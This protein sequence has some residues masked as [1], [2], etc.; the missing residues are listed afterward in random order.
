MESLV[1]VMTMQ[2]LEKYGI[3]PLEALKRYG[4]WLENEIPNDGSY[5]YYMTDLK[6]C[7]YTRFIVYKYDV[8]TWYTGIEKYDEEFIKKY[9]KSFSLVSHREWERYSQWDLDHEM[10]GKKEPTMLKA[11]LDPSITKRLYELYIDSEI[12]ACK[13]RNENYDLEQITNRA[14]H[15]GW[16]IELAHQ[17]ILDLMIYERKSKDSAKANES[18]INVKEQEEQLSNKELLDNLKATPID[19]IDSTLLP[20]VNLVAREKEVLELVKAEIR[21]S[22]SLDYKSEIEIYNQEVAKDKKLIMV[23]GIPGAGKS[24]IAPKYSLKYKARLI[25]SNVIKTYLPE[26]AKNGSN[27]ALVH[28]ESSNIAMELYRQ[29]ILQGENIIYL[30]MGDKPKQIA[31]LIKLAKDQGYEIT[32]IYV[33]SLPNL[34]K[35]RVLRRFLDSGFF[36]SPE[37][38]SSCYEQSTCKVQYTYDVLKSEVNHFIRYTNNVVNKKPSIVEK[39]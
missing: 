6:E 13:R 27:A 14:Y 38:V 21:A 32:L 16:I 34:A 25:D 2:E 23:I 28:K 17:G 19:Q 39:E 22:M 1:N 26:F 12:Q 33:E 5:T 31:A 37:L 18:N 24:T 3:D 4:K 8:A 30:K 11:L 10:T 9:G 29:S 15:E 36:V 7:L 20:S 35:A